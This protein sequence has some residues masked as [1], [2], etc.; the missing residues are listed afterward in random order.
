MMIRVPKR[1]RLFK[2]AYI[3]EY[4]QNKKLVAGLNIPL[5]KY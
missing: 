1:G 4:Q 2:I 5:E 3:I